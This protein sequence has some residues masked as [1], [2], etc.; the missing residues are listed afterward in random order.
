MYSRSS[1]M[2]GQSPNNKMPTHGMRASQST[3]MFDYFT[4]IT[5]TS[6]RATSFD[7]K[8]ARELA[9]KRVGFCRK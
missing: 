2:K 1:A 9:V 7:N 8:E 3:P 4:V 6:W 5:P